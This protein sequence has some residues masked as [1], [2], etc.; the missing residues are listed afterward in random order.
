M[1]NV[2]VDASII[3]Q[4]LQYAFWAESNSDS[5]KSLWLECNNKPEDLSISWDPFVVRILL[6]TP[7]ILGS[8]SCKCEVVIWIQKVSNSLEV[9]IRCLWKE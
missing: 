4:V 2:D 8:P 5:V 1:K 6:I 9:P 3:P 7:R